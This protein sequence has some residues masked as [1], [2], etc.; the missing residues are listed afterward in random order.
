MNGAAGETQLTILVF[1]GPCLASPQP[2]A[3]PL[4]PSPFR[5]GPPPTL[6]LTFMARTRDATCEELSRLRK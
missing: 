2:L 4:E 6:R 5:L 3:L 1:T